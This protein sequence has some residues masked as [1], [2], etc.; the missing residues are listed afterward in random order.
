MSRKYFT[1]SSRQNSVVVNT[2]T[3][4]NC[5]DFGIVSM[6]FP[7]ILYNLKSSD[8]HTIRLYETSQTSNLDVSVVAGNWTISDLLTQIQD[9]LNTGSA[10]S[11][12]A[13]TCS[14]DSIT[15]LVSIVHS[16]E[17]FDLLFD[18]GTTATMAGS[19]GLTADITASLVS[20]VYVAECQDIYNLTPE[21]SVE[22]HCDLS[23]T[24]YYKDGASSSL[25]HQ[26]QLT[27]GFGGIVFYNNLSMAENVL[28]CNRKTV[29]SFTITLKDT[30]GNL[31]PEDNLLD[32]NLVMYIDQSRKIF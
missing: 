18:T 14:Y 21:T 28:Q 1:V 13:Y 5:D 3:L 12:G 25:V 2:P 7:N 32:W 22:I 10:F 19:L 15:N 4:E 29:S 24:N 9:S 20:G 31:L 11:S 8:T 26:L 6:T 27:E 30:S 16:V 17:T 23:Q